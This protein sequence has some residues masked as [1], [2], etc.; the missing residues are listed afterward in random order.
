MKKIDYGS[1]K[2][3]LAIE[4]PMVR[5]GL[6]NSLQ[7]EGFQRFE[8]VASPESLHSALSG[9]DAFDVIVTATEIAAEFVPPH[10]ARLR[11]GAFAH[12][13]LPVVIE[14]LA[15]SDAD[16]VRKVI[17]SGPDDLLQLPVSP[18]Q[19]LS[20]LAVLADKRKPF[21]VT[22]DY[23]GPDRRQTARPGAA[24]TPTAEMP[25]PLAMK[26]EQRSDAAVLEAMTAGAARLRQMRIERYAFELQW[27]LRAIRLLFQAEERDAGRLETFCG[28]IK[29]VLGE[30][31]KPLPPDAGAIIA[32]IAERVA[33]GVAIVAKNGFSADATVLNGLGGLVNTLTQALHA[34]L[35]AEV[36]EAAAQARNSAV[37]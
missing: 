20:R 2:M 13:P 36:L 6:L 35:S 37:K 23:I 10:I 31:P 29:T 19:L 21:I 14:L 17:D 25:N 4:N 9:G 28:R 12:H 3:L 11:Q 30:L 24:A 33:L 15:A 34:T 5:K 22:S 27:L 26:L 8:E 18:G 7:H 1:V 16:Y 32:P